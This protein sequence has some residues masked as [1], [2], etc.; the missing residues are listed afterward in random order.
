MFETA[1][2]TAWPAIQAGGPWVFV[3][4]VG[5]FLLTGRLITLRAHDARVAD[6]RAT[7]DAQRQTVDALIRQKD[8]LLAGARISARALDV[9]R[10]QSELGD[11]D[12]VTAA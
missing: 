12:D 2:L 1:I 3:A 8:D 9:I 11:G 6:L 7:I 5:Y 10:R 4:L